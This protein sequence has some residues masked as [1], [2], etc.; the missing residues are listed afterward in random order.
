MALDDVGFLPHA[1]AALDHV[2]V[3]GALGEEGVVEPELGHLFLLHRDEHVA[4]EL[5]LALRLAHPGEGAQEF[6]R[7]V[8]VVEMIGAELFQGRLDLRGLA[9]AHE[10][11]VDVHE[12]NLAPVEG[13]EEQRR[14]DGGIDPA[15]DEEEHLFLSHGAFDVPGG[16]R[17]ERVHVPFRLGARDG[18]REILE[19][20]KP[21]LGVGH[22]GM[23]LEAP[24]GLRFVVHDRRHAV[25]GRGDRPVA[26]G[27][28]FDRVAVA[29]PGNERRGYA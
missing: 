24:D 10:P 8:D 28:L 16:D 6:F 2:R 11:G 29:H 27:E 20:L 18:E 15:R 26:G 5:A 7:G 13:P 25:L 21:E 1:L 23:E 3:E 19:N 22:L 12:V 4:D 17:Q 14:H 9:L